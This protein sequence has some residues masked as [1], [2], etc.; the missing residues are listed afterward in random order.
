MVPEKVEYN[1]K[2]GYQVVH[3]C[4]KCGKTVKNILDFESPVQPDSMEVALRLM[5]GREKG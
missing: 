1:S 3:R 2:K 4:L 5:T